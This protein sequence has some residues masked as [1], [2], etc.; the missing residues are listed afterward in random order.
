MATLIIVLKGKKMLY[1]KYHR[2]FIRQFKKGAKVGFG[3]RREELVDIVKIEPCRVDCHDGVFKGIHMT[4]I[5]YDWA[6]VF[7][8]GYI[9][10][11]VKV[12]EDAI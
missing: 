8:S 3:H 4:G 5:Y 1:K 2:N 7:P 12:I 9:N 6:L 10:H 11:D